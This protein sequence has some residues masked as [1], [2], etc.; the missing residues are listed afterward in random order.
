MYGAGTELTTDD[1]K[2]DFPVWILSVEKPVDQ[3]QILLMVC[4]NYHP[5]TQQ[6]KTKMMT[7]IL[8]Y[9]GFLSQKTSCPWSCLDLWGVKPLPPPKRCRLLRLPIMKAVS[10][11]SW[12]SSSLILAIPIYNHEG[13]KRVITVLWVRVVGACQC[14]HPVE[15]AP[16]PCQAS[17]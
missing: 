4:V 9:Y 8:S 11:A 6:I 16:Q 17:E 3:L 7:R 13:I 5:P 10:P 2:D 14:L 1:Q 15:V 12:N